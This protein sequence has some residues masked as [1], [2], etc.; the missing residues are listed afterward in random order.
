[1][2]QTGCDVSLHYNSTVK[3]YLCVILVETVLVKLVIVP[4]VTHRNCYCYTEALMNGWR[5]LVTNKQTS[6]S[7]T[8]FLSTVNLWIQVGVHL[9]HLE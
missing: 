3:F 5:V 8:W 1:M 4:Y 7:H 9:P 6:F 2:L